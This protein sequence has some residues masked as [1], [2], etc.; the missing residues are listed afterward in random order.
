MDVVMVFGTA[1]V[2]LTC[3]DGYVSARERTVST[4]AN[5]DGMNASL[6]SPNQFLNGNLERIAEFGA[7]VTVW[8][9]PD[10]ET[11]VAG[12]LMAVARHLGQPVTCVTATDGDFAATAPER[13]RAARVRRAEL[14]IALGLLGV[15]DRVALGLRDGECDTVDHDIGVALIA[16]VLAARQPDTVVTFGPDGLTGHPD[17]C[18]VSRWTAE[19]VRIACPD[20]LLL[21][22]SLTPAMA[23]EDRDINDRFDVYAPGLPLTHSEQ[24]LVVDLSISGPWLDLKL[25][26]LRAHQSQTAGL[27]DVIGVD[28]YRRWIARE[29]M[30]RYD[31]Y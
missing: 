4:G 3:A 6:V 13:R 24:Q 18:A 25:A 27:I 26:A 29:P 19:A 5:T 7:I 8:A 12:G 14:D 11:Y 23:D 9:H 31:D 10:D 16:D 15:T 21:C 20:A 28:R 2:A 30:I 1:R 17:H 22:P